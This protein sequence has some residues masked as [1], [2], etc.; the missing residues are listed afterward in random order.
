MNKILHEIMKTGTVCLSDGQTVPL[1]SNISREEG[2]FLRKMILMHRPNTTIEIGLAFG[3]SALFMCDALREINPDFRHYIIDPNQS[4]EYHNA[5]L[6]NLKESGFADNIVFFEEPSEIA[7][8]KILDQGHS[9]DLAFLDGWHTFDHTLIDFFYVNKMLK[10][11]GLVAFDD[12]TWGSVGR[13]IDHVLSYP[14]FEFE[15]AMPSVSLPKSVIRK[16][17]RLSILKVFN[18]YL[19]PVLRYSRCVVLRKCSLDERPYHWHKFF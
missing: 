8:P 2:E 15:D 18:S 11:G 16:M 3:I 13:V 12:S 14:C 5:G 4:N 6:N 7:L 10:A 19:P 1:R 9:F 17:G